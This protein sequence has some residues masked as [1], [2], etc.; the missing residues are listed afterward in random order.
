MKIMENMS[1]KLFRNAVTLLLAVLF[2]AVP[3]YATYPT[4]S[5]AGTSNSTDYS[6]GTWTASPVAVILTCNAG[7][8]Q[9]T[10]TSYCIDTTDSCDPTSSGTRYSSTFDF[11]SDGISYMRYASD[12]D[13]GSWGD[14]SSSSLW[15]DTTP[16]ELTLADDA[17]TTWTNENTVTVSEDDGNGSGVV[18]TRWIAEANPECDST[19]DSQFDSSGTEGNS[20]EAK[21]DTLY[22]SKYICF[23]ATD[24]AGNSNYLASSQITHLDT[25]PPTVSAGPDITTNAVFTRDGEATDSGSG[26]V[27]E[28]WEKILRSGDCDIR[29]PQPTRHDR[30]RG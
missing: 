28:Y 11:S 30:E 16:P 22:Q 4:T 2:L 27:S 15:I 12:N 14:V 26:I 25:T 13:S 19:L 23:R 7:T 17:S 24:A 1:P 10:N 20:M 18:D 29:I 9:C 21:N 3:V 6:F 5:V 8:S